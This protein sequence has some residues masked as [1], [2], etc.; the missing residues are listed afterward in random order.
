MYSINVLSRITF[1]FETWNC[2]VV[3][4]C[5]IEM[6]V[7]VLGETEMSTMSFHIVSYIYF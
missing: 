6:I 5:D 1:V 4:G 3:V 2:L 7:I